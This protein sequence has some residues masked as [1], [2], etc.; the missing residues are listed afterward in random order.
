MSRMSPSATAGSS[1]TGAGGSSE[2]EEE[3]SQEEE[4]PAELE[5]AWVVGREGGG[6]GLDEEEEGW[7]PMGCRSR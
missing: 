5:R 3:V 6:R 7:L 1:S 4:E 2:E